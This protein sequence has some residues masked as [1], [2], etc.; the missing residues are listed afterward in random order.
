MV[1]KDIFLENV[2]MN[3][4]QF[5]ACHVQVQPLDWMQQ[6]KFKTCI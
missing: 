4:G 3:N 1:T 5:S 2:A 6:V